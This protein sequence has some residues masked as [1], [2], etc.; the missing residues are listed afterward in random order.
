MWKITKC[1]VLGGHDVDIIVIVVPSIHAGIN[2]VS[3]FWY[4]PITNYKYEK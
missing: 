3:K 2:I 1:G 4:W